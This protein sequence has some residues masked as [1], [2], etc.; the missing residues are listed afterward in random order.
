MNLNT[1]EPKPT[2]PE[3]PLYTTTEAWTYLSISKSKFYT[4]VEMHNPTVFRVGRKVLYPK[5]SLDWIIRTNID[6]HHFYSLR[7]EIGETV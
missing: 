1:L 2:G 6:T 3:D 5:S 7:S 4:L